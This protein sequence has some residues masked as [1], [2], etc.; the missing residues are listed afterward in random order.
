MR[1]SHEWRPLLL[2]N[3]SPRVTSR[4]TGLREA[5]T[6][7]ALID[8]D[9]LRYNLARVR[10]L[11]PDSRVMAVIK[12][13]GYGHGWARVAGVLEAADAFA[14]AR[15]GEAIALRE[16]G[17]TQPVV[18]LEG[19]TSAQE[20]ATI[21]QYELAVVVHHDM[22]IDLLETASLLQPLPVWLKID[23]GMHRL[24]IPPARARAAMQRLEDCAG[25]VLQ[26]LMTHL[27]SADERDN[28][29][30]GDQLDCFA[31]ATDGLHAARSIANSAGLLAWPASHADWVRPG[32]MLYGVSPF[33]DT[34]GVQEALRPV[35]TLRTH[36]LAVNHHQRGDRIGYGGTWTCPVDMPV[37]VV[38]I[39][40]GDG[41]PRHAAE[42]TPV[43]INNQRVPLVG[44][45]SMDMLSVDLRACPEARAGDP[46]QLWGAGL[47]VEEVARHAGTIAY[48]LLCG[49]TSRV[50]FIEVSAA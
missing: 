16:A 15:L 7:Q 39:G 25:V 20:L 27:A 43:L 42:G 50:E 26:G 32:I 45:V 46:V 31:Q 10:A 9:A 40:Y 4:S 47:P 1:A 13:N 2:V 21:V 8:T 37:G 44:R 34:V 14:V 30:T 5:H 48:E 35:M 49:V 38:G 23:T 6:P 11:A 36:L 22:Q 24:G 19:F 28:P 29:Q 3:P 41:Y 12:A 33:H 17:I 18:L